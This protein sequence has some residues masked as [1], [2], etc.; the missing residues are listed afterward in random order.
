MRVVDV[1]E[2]TAKIID[3]FNDFGLQ[4]LMEKG[5]DQCKD[6]SNVYSEVLEI[7][8]KAPSLDEEIRQKEKAEY[9][10]GLLSAWNAS[11]KLVYLDYYE[12]ESLKRLFDT[13][14]LLVVMDTSS[15]ERVMETLNRD[16]K[17]IDHI[18]EVLRDWKKE[19]YTRANFEKIL[20]DLEEKDS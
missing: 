10:R 6:L 9:Q 14:Y 16:E 12:K 13:D 4:K 7:L 20:D 8:A 1:N 5:E 17:Y 15:P 11:K 19:G 18:K 3:Y 2:I